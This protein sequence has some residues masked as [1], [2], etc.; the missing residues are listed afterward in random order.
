LLDFL[1]TGVTRSMV[2][3]RCREV[4]VSCARVGEAK[5][6]RNMRYLRSKPKPFRGDL[7]AFLPSRVLMRVLIAGPASGRVAQVLGGS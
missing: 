3:T 5:S 2:L 6:P 1:D 7:R 4:V